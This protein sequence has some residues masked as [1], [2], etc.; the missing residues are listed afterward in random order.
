[1]GKKCVWIK[2][3]YKKKRVLVKKGRNK[4]RNSDGCDGENFNGNGMSRLKN[5]SEKKE[6]REL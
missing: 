6:E 4:R 1:M 3:M 2:R 5:V